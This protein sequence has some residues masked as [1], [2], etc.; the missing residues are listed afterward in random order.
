MLF[1]TTALF[2]QLAQVRADMFR[3]LHTLYVG[4]EALSPALMNAVRHDCPDLALHNIYGPTENTTF[5]TFFE[6][7]RDY[8]GP[9]PIG[10]PISNSTA[11]I[12]DTKGRLLPIGVPGELC[13]GGDGVAKG[14]L[15]R[16]RPDK[17]S[18]F[19]SSFLAWR[20]NIPY[21]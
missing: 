9:I 20:K 7:K 2:N 17:C 4:G 14:Y 3:G 21:R 16:D 1:L 19:S 18:F 11:Y 15:N 10:K 5:S 8:A 6:M 12:L 13:V